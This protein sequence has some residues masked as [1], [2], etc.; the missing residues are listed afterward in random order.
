MGT[1]VI[2]VIILFLY[3]VAI[4]TA[5]EDESRFGYIPLLIAGVVLYFTGFIRGTEIVERNSDTLLIPSV[6][7][8]CEELDGVKKC[9]TTYIYKFKK[10]ENE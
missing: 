3:I 8:I 2:L 1:I 5:R 9:D 4:E 7:T 6:K 10:E